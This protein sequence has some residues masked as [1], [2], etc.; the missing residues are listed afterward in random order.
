[1][2]GRCPLDRVSRTH[3]WGS[4]RHVLVLVFNVDIRE[5][6]VVSGEW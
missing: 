6:K 4:Y 5:V 3:D 2:G 1:M